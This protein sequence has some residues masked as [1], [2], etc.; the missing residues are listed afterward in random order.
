MN[1]TRHKPPKRTNPT[2]HPVAFDTLDAMK[3]VGC[4]AESTFY[5]LQAKRLLPRPVKLGEKSVYL[6]VELEAA[7]QKAKDERDGV[8]PSQGF[9]ERAE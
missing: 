1:S 2:V 6:R 3:F 4:K 8:S 9:Q 7:M 5:K